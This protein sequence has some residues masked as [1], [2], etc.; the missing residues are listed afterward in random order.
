MKNVIIYII[1]VAINMALMMVLM[2]P[3]VQSNEYYTK[4]VQVCI[5]VVTF[6]LIRIYFKDRGLLKDKN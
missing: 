4:G 6:I 5:V 1:L 3:T 2:S